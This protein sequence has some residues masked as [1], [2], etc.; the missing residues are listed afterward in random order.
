MEAEWDETGLR[1]PSLLANVA[2]EGDCGVLDDADSP[3]L[4]RCS[5]DSDGLKRLARPLLITPGCIP[6]KGT[7]KLTVPRMRC[8][9]A[10]PVNGDCGG[11]RAI[12]AA[13]R[14]P[15]ECPRRTT[16]VVG[17]SCGASLRYRLEHLM[18]AR[19]N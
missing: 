14:P 1:V 2:V 13:T 9:N 6:R 10:C 7:S 11:S 5:G 4:D 8:R 19:S 17:D 18:H 3:V 12:S 16:S 15:I